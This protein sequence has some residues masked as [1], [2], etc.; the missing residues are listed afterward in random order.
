LAESAADHVILPVEDYYF[1]IVEDRLKGWDFGLGVVGVPVRVHVVSALGEC[2]G[3]WYFEEVFCFREVE[4]RGKWK[5]IQVHLRL[6][7]IIH[8]TPTG[9]RT[10]AIPYDF[11]FLT[12]LLILPICYEF[13]Y[14][15]LVIFHLL[16]EFL[17]D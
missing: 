5:I 1:H 4:P 14:L 7:Y 11:H 17:V 2:E 6:L 10:Y 3:I 15:K 9:H 8:K 16:K 12:S 13:V